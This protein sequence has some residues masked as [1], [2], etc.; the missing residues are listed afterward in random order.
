MTPRRRDLLEGQDIR[1]IPLDHLRSQ[2]GL[3]SQECNVFSGTIYENIAYG[4]KAPSKAQVA[5]VARMSRVNE[6]QSGC[7]AN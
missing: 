2:I 7:R 5:E 3:V 1:S 6:L 4:S